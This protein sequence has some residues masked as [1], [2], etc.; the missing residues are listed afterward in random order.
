MVR[1]WKTVVTAFSALALGLP[2]VAWAADTP[3][4]P[5][6][7][8]HEPPY[9]IHIARATGPIVVDGDLSD[10][11]WKDAQPI[12]KWWETNPGDNVEPKVK[13]VGRMAYDDK[14]LY[15]ALEFD[16]PDPKKIRAPYADRDNVD[17][18][19]DYGGIILDA[20][21]DR[22]TA[23][24][25]LANPRGIQ[26]DSM[27]SD[28]S[29]SE[30]N[31]PD[32]FWDSAAKI[33]DHGWT[34]EIRIPFS[35]LRY[36]KKDVQTW[37]MML[38]RNYPRDRRY[39]MFTVRQPRESNCFICNEQTLEGLSGLPHGGNFVIAPY[40]VAH[41][42][43]TPR[44]DLGT[45]LVNPAPNYDAG[46]DAKW[47]PNAGTSI[48]ATINPD[49]SQVESDVAQIS[50][51]ERFALFY[52]EKRPFFLER[53]DLFQTPVQAVY[54][55]T[56]TDPL[57]GARATG[58]AGNTSYT[59]LITH[60]NGGGS[61]ILPGPYG[62]DFA[63]QD[64]QSTVGIARV[65]QDFGQSFVSGLVT[66]REIEGG[67]YNRVMGPDFQWRPKQGETMTGQ[68]LFSDTRTPDLGCAPGTCFPEEWDGRRMQSHAAEL[69]YQH[70]DKHWDAFANYRDYGDDFRADV[71]FVPQVGFREQY[72]EGGYSRYPTHG[73]LSRQ[74]IFVQGDYVQDRDKN[75]IDRFVTDGTGMDG[76][77][78]S[79]LRF[80]V[81]GEDVR[82]IDA[83]TG[84]GTVLPRRQFYTTL[85]ASPW[86][87]L[88]RVEF[89]GNYGVDVDFTRARPGHGGQVALTA[90]LRPTNHIQID[91]LG[92]RRWLDVE[93]DGTESRLFTAQVQR[94]RGVYTFNSKSFLRLIVQR[95][96][97]S[98]DS[99]LY[100]FTP[101]LP[102]KSED[103]NWSALFAYKLNWQSVL[104]F[105]YQ[106]SREWSP[107]TTELEQAGRS[108]FLKVSYA[109]QH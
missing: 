23:V 10:P 44:G 68:I 109:F 27:N 72:V 17:S 53:V 38:Y 26:Y 91:L 46:V 8:A 29:G 56:I 7:A 102:P 104:F 71:G 80:W 66:D 67:G 106:D 103:I 76:L 89:D 85:S 81:R 75:L 108:F 78:N 1:R 45:E 5:P 98:Q 28:A 35:S 73:F 16:D 31:S 41:Q 40:G 37:G 84:V 51:N 65:R 99:A 79:F 69:W 12:E 88:T 21:N 62:S 22:K 43:S 4:P 47:A 30:D 14:Y 55:R 59:A 11:A 49:F 32:W 58:Q 96:A 63:D 95:V 2:A 57:W 100:G 77:A 20:D 19:T 60:D 34:L 64:F 86:H 3:A 87:W 105:G 93:H 101:P 42:E 50:A 74:R 15:V 83:L 52:P 92:N 48:D 9:T 94:F 54:T 24:L 70:N 82:A 33:N 107:T 36:P 39:Q 90:T 6:A 18:T 25:F 97:E 13:N 61:V